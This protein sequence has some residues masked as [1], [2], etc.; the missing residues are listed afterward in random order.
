MSKVIKLLAV[1]LMAWLLS[2]LLGAEE[3]PRIFERD[4][5]A[6]K[7]VRIDLASG[8]CRLHVSQDNAVKVRNETTYPVTRYKPEAS[9]EGDELIVKEDHSGK[10]WSRGRV[11]WDIWVPAGMKVSFRSASGDLE[12]KKLDLQLDVHTASGDVDLA[13]LKGKLGIHTASGDIELAEPSADVKIN[14]ASGDVEISGSTGDLVVH[15]A[16]GDVEVLASTGKMVV[17]TAS[18]DIELK[19]VRGEGSVRCASGDIEVPGL[20]PTG[21]W[22]MSVASGSIHVRLAESAAHDMT[23]ASASGDVLLDYNGNAIKGSIEVMA[24]ENRGDI[25]S[26]EK[27][28]KDTLFIRG[29]KFERLSISHGDAPKIKLKTHSGD[30]ELRR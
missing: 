7:S 16:S 29:T 8:D 21:A 25:R 13:G 30:V 22:E 19:K 11:Q 2:P 9:M 18:G 23:L 28:K 10:G 17:R 3:S 4:F 27:G 5:K 15:T 6:V 1:I 14:T 20:T 12:G 24:A 26:S